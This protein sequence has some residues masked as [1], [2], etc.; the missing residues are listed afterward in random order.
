M[1]TSEFFTIFHCDTT[2]QA[3]TGALHLPHGIVQTPVFMPVGTNGA[4][5][6][7]SKDDLAAIG[8]EIIL[9]NTY[10]LYLRPGV[11]IV[12]QAGG[13]HGFSQWKRNILTDSGGFQVFSLAQFRKI[14]EEGV[15]FRSHIDG[16]L[17]SFTPESVVDIQA[18]YNSDIQ[19]QLDVCT[20]HGIDKKEAQRALDITSRW[21]VR[22]QKQWQVQ[23]Q[24]GYR[25]ALFPIV[26][27]NFFMELRRQSAEF[28]AALDVPGIAIGGLSVGE[29]AAL[30]ADM[31]AYTVQFLPVHKP[32][33]VMGIGTP[34]YILEAIGDGIDMFD[35]V[36][37]TRNAR[38]GSYFTHD[39]NLS[40]KQERF[41][42]DFSPIDAECTC[43][44]CKNYS[45]AYLRHLF[46]EQEILSAMLATYHNLF[47]LHTLVQQAR[48]AINAGQFAQFRKA[49]LERFAAH[50]VH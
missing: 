1:D 48:T 9:A 41:A 5:K 22:A 39:G 35:C 23:Q 31:L 44:V 21:A 12:E 16:S 18:R 15:S 20:G 6:A 34:E 13:L 30:F 40:I 29:P 25:G 14:T 8:F 7:M 17:K 47:F 37:P 26:Q 46:K 24:A 4:V 36:L 3:R 49:F 28:V 32:R 43:K 11:D 50:A 2:T 27:G 19:M 42:H 10:H 45:R 33:Y 38:N